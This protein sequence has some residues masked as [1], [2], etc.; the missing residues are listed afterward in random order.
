MT[1][2]DLLLEINDAYRGDEDAP[3]FGSAEASYWLRVANRKLREL[4]S[5]EKQSWSFATYDEDGVVEVPV[6]SA[7]TDELAISV[8]DWLVY[9]TAA[10]L[11]YNDTTYEDKFGD[12]I[13]Q[14]NNLYVQMVSNS[15]RSAASA[16]KP[17]S[18]FPKSLTYDVTR[19]SG[20]E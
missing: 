11:A 4:Y 20:V 9:A 5:D 17:E 10:D 6:L 15:R 18:Q 1:V 2:A 13:G 12:L 16:T 8:P 3:T 7:S 19:I 14:A